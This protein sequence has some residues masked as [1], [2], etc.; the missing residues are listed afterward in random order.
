MV[1]AHMCPG[2]TASNQKL[3]RR[4]AMRVGYFHSLSREEYLKKDVGKGDTEKSKE[5]FGKVVAI[6][7]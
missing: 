4:W 7:E 3:I 2:P 6:S 5:T 1:Q